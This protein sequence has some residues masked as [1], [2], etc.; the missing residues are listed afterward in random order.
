MTHEVDAAVK[1][2]N[3]LFPKQHQPKIHRRNGVTYL[4][5]QENSSGASG[6][7]ACKGFCAIFPLIEQAYR[8]G[9]PF[10][11]F[12]GCNDRIGVVATPEAIDE[13]MA[14][15]VTARLEETP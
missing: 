12:S 15:C 9:R 13:F 2:Y 10:T 11:C 3:E 14:K 7:D 6:V 5:V 8:N 4:M 1:R